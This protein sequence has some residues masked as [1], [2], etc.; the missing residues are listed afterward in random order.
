MVAEQFLNG[1][2]VVLI[3]RHTFGPVSDWRRHLLSFLG[4]FERWKFAT[5]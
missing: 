3:P 1:A 5:L 4:L 2:D